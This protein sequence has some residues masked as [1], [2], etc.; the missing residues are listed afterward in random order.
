MSLFVL[1]A[2]ITVGSS[3]LQSGFPHPFAQLP[4][5]WGLALAPDRGRYRTPRGRGGGGGVGR[6]NGDDGS[7]AVLPQVE[8]PSEQPSL[9]LRSVAPGL[10]FLDSWSKSDIVVRFF[11]LSFFFVS[12]GSS[13]TYFWFFS[14]Q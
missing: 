2:F 1:Q 3:L 8:Q 13:E 10:L 6:Q 4:P 9:R 7:A 11:Y 12:P 5:Q 14:T